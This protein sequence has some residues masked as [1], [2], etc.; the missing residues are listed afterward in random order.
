MGSPNTISFLGLSELHACSTHGLTSRTCWRALFL[1]SGHLV[2]FLPPTL[3]KP[4]KTSWR[5]PQTPGDVPWGRPLNFGTSPGLCDVMNTNW[6][7]GSFVNK[8]CRHQL[9]WITVTSYDVMKRL[10]SRLHYE[11]KASHGQYSLVERHH[12]GTKMNDVV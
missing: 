11:S 6:G 9:S 5:C 7:V 4:P 2:N 10:F 12:C 3:P 8:T 1:V